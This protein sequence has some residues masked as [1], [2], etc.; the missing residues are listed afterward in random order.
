MKPR[1]A[2]RASGRPGWTERHRYAV[3]SGILFFLPSVSWAVELNGS[4]FQILVGDEVHELGNFIEFESVLDEAT[5][6]ETGRTNLHNL[7]KNLSS[8]SLTPVAESYA[9]LI[10][11]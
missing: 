7:L 4:R 8:F 11:K 6:E 10:H 9:D 1:T 2:G 5:D 3:A